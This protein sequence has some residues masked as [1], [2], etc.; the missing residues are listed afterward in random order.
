MLNRDKF[1]RGT[2]IQEIFAQLGV[3]EAT[4]AF[5]LGKELAKAK[6]AIT[7]GKTYR[8]ESS[9]DWGYLTPPDEA[10]SEHVRLTQRSERSERRRRERGEEEPG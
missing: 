10:A 4:H 2:D 3:T 8:Q 5:Y 7:L 6:L 1:V 9:L